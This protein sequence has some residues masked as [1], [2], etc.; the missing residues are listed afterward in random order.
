M[1]DGTNDVTISVPVSGDENVMVPV[2]R[3]IV[4]NSDGSDSILLQRRSIRA[5]AVF[6]L[7][8]LPG[9]T[10]RAGESP[11]DAISR[12]V[13]E[14]TGVAITSV[15]GIEIDVLD[16]HRSIA[17]VTPLVVIGGVGGSYPAVHVVVV[18]SGTGGP[19]DRAGESFDVQWWP[20]E[21]VRDE[22]RNEPATFV[23]STLAALNAYFVSIE[24]E[25]G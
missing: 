10:W 23:P 19:K 15:S 6:G 8:E 2:I 18:A 13:L 11:D 14:E 5:E 24:S 16:S 1:Y 21:S 7:I 20:I 9:G 3:A 4:E 12:E 25:S 22:T 17:T